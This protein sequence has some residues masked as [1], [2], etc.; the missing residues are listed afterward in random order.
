[1]NS[2]YELADDTP[3]PAA[4]PCDAKDQL[5]SGE[6]GAGGVR[7][8]VIEDDP[9][10]QELLAETLEDYFGVGCLDLAGTCA[11]AL[12]RRL[13]GYDL[14][15]C[16]YNL[17]DGTGLDVLDGLRARCDVPV[18]ML[19][20]ESGCDT[21]KLAIRR[22][23]VDYVVKAGEYL[24]TLPLTVEKNLAAGRIR[25]ESSAAADVL[26]R[27]ADELEQNLRQV[28]QLAATDPMTGCYNRRAF[29]TVF[30]QLFAEAARADSDLSCVMIDLDK[31]KGVNDTL[32]H[33][34]GD[35]LIKSAARAIRAQL[36]KM[37]VACRYG[38]D[39]FILLLPTADAADATQ[40]AD[41]IRRD[42]ALLSAQLLDGEA[43]T[44]SIGVGSLRQTAPR[45]D[46]A[47]ALMLAADRALYV[48]K[49]NGRDR[50][51][52]AA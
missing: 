47:E 22:G 26:R 1:M 5:P 32:G 31:F 4:D 25:R 43:K 28:E 21:A 8:L 33:A 19:T 49:E 18:M 3:P 15:L 7:L 20:G 40:V 38:G 12:D 39:E 41:R 34:V 51:C 46:H 24:T 35:E 52:A 45:P 10:Q 23:A 29:E 30:G 17:P 9:D 48:A 42:Y 37:D 14:I 16:D 44:M 13:D 6:G 2:I 36:R 27:R 50:I 11:A